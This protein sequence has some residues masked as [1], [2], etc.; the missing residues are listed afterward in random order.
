MLQTSVESRPPSVQWTRETK[1]ARAEVYRIAN[2][3]AARIV[4]ADPGKYPG[5]MQEWA[6]LVLAGGG[7]RPRTGG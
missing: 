5:V 1:A 6:G 4:L 3:T 7:C 2:E